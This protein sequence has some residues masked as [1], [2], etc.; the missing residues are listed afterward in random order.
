MTLYD[1][2]YHEIDFDRALLTLL[3]YAI[4]F[5]SNLSSI[6]HVGKSIV[7]ECVPEKL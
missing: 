2:S 3:C 7:N 5:C 4:C 1:I 6:D